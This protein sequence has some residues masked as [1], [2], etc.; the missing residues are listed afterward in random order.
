MDWAQIL[1]FILAILFAIFL[2]VA[3]A[4]AVVIISIT[5]QLKAAASSAE[6]TIHAI[7]GS[8]ANLSK[9]AL[10]LTLARGVLGQLLKKPRKKN[11]S[12]SE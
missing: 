6:R 1:V 12:A 10:P 7:E 5:K 9:M 4:L 2:I 8:V 3:I 11:K